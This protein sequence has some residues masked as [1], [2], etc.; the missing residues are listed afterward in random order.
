MKNAEEMKKLLTE[1][2]SVYEVMCMTGFPIYIIGNYTEDVAHELDVS[3]CIEETLHTMLQAD[4]NEE[5]I[6][7][8]LRAESL[9][10]EDINDDYCYY[11]DLDYG[12]KDFTPTNVVHTS[13]RYEPEVIEYTVHYYGKVLCPNFYVKKDATD[14]EILEQ[15]NDKFGL[16]PEE[17]TV[18]DVRDDGT[19][20]SIQHVLDDSMLVLLANKKSV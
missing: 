16:N 2:Q 15:L 6:Y 17:F 18:N 11:I 4:W 8:C 12:I 1:G 14:D 9:S 20:L 19:M 3:G 13:I 5:D 10:S 7:S